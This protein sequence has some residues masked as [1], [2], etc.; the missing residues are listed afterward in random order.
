MAF[1][2]PVALVVRGARAG[3]HTLALVPRAVTALERLGR[4]VDRLPTRRRPE[5]GSSSAR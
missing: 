3:V 5:L 4:M 1:P 2:N